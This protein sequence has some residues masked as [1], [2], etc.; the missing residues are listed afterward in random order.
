MRKIAVTA[1]AAA[2]ALGVTG[3]GLAQGTPPTITVTASETELTLGVAGPVAAGPTRFEVTKSGGAELEI[4]FAALRPGVTR[5]QFEAVLRGRDPEAAIDLA[6]LDGGVALGAGDER[7]AVTFSLRPN[8][9]YILING[10][11]ERPSEWETAELTVGAQSNGATAPRA[12]ATV[13]MVD[14]RF[15]GAR[16]LPR[17]GV[18]RFQ[19]AGW[20][21]HFAIAAPLRPGARPRVVGRALRRNQQRRL[22]RLVD[23]ESTVQ[24]QAL[25]TR[26]AVDYNEV[27][28]PR[29]GRYVMVCFF[30]GHHAQGMY[31]FIRVR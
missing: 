30:E 20:A 4:T 31:R 25:I 29:R 8:A 24:P 17:D 6:N 23:F 11:G 22:G 9:T 18:V 28:F 16:I 13:Q 15:R 5:G 7:R 1:A 26:G 10:S 3:A 21:P 2:V 19:N 27:R 12:D 14:L